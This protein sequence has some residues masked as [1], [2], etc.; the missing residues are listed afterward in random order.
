MTLRISFKTSPQ[1]VDWADARRHVAARRGAVRGR[2]PAAFDGAWMNDHLTDMDPARPGPSLEAVTVLADAGPPRPGLRIGHAVLS[3]T[4]RHPVLVAKAATVLDHVTGGRFV[5]GLGAGWF[6]NEHGPFGIDLPPIGERIRR[7]NLRR[8]RAP[9]PVLAGGRRRAR[10][11]PRRPV[12][13]AQRAPPTCPRRSPRAARRSY[14]GGQKPRGIRLAARAAQGWLLPGTEAGD[15]AYFA[16]KRD[17]IVRALEEEGRDP[18]RSSSSPRSHRA[19]RGRTGHA[20][21]SRP[22]GSS[23]RARREI[24][25]GDARRARTGGPGR[26]APGPAPAAPRRGRVT[27]DPRPLA[28]DIAAVDAGDEAGIEAYV[29]I[30]NA[31]TPDSPD[32]AANAR[33]AEATY[34]GQGTT[35]LATDAAGTAVGTASAGR[36]WMHGPDYERGGSACGSCP[37][38]GG[39]ASA[40]RCSGRAASR[41]GRGQDRLPDRAL[42]GPR[43]GASLPRR[44][45]LRRGRADEGGPPGPGRRRGAAGRATRRH[46]AHDARRAARPPA[47]RPPRRRRGVSRTSRPAAS[48]CTPARSTSSSPA[49]WTGPTCRAR[50]SSSPWTT[51]TGEV[52]GLR[53]PDPAGGQRHDR[54]CTT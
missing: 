32:S 6:E 38:R 34:P 36:I 30:R 22:G 42:R 21:S 33:W 24:V 5:L 7:L 1:G 2:R 8:G 41:P 18:R 53:Q 35:F 54:R 46:L 4:F 10:R 16:A 37:R 19:G 43:R 23:P 40:R 44:A 49:T 13:P 50:A 31:T 39:R 3:N 15:V 48:R 27:E 52:G 12:L 9:R 28:I 17:L 20:P 11:H 25:L 47:G 51:A 29:A 26:R 14:L 45:R